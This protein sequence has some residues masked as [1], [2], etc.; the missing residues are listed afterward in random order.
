MDINREGEMAKKVRKVLTFVEK[1]QKFIHAGIS[2][3]AVP[4][5]LSN[6]MADLSSLDERIKRIL[7]LVNR[8]NRP[9][10]NMLFFVMYDI[11]SDKVRHQVVK[12]LQRKGCT[13]VQRSIFLA[14][15]AMSEYDCIRKDLAEVQAAYENNDS[16]LVVPISADY[17]RSMKVI[18]QKVELDIIM[19]NKNTLFF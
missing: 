3:S 12:Y 14:D 4:N 11:E 18:G 5:R 13:R 8:I 16:I 17:L 7:G 6:D 15:L 2:E 1:M 10:S 19:H 9:A